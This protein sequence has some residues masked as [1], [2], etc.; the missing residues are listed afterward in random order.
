MKGWFQKVGRWAGRVLY[1]DTHAGRGRHVSGEL[2]SPLVALKTLLEHSYREQ[3]FKKSEFRFFFIERDTANLN[4]LKKEL[5]ALGSLPRRVHVE[6]VATDSF[7]SLST[8]VDTLRRDGKQMA[9]AFVFVDPYGFKVPGRLLADL[10]A[11]GRVELFINVIWRE[12]D[13]AVAQRPRAGEG[14]ANTLDAIFDG[15][16][17]RGIEGDD[18]DKR[19]D[20]AVALL[21]KKVGAKLWT[22]IRMVSGGKATRYLLLHLTNHDKGRDLM[23]DCIWKICPDGGYHVHQSDDP[24]QPL[25]IEP[26]PDLR[27]LQDWLVE[28]LR[29]RPCRWRELQEAIRPK[30]WRTTHLNE[31]I[32][33]L[34]R[35]RT[36]VAEGFSGALSAKAN[37][38]L[39]LR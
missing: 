6:T 39:R 15:D 32:R 25:L 9:P 19:L 31:M 38:L 10:M 26:E 7:E 1:V 11:F 17:W 3:L 13:M 29:V 23:K 20:Q 14:M 4:E 2:G 37:P 5:A 30:P 36:I 34:L 21:G 35:K 27:P 24:S 22:Y 28:H 16:E 12:L 8:L 18:V 33:D